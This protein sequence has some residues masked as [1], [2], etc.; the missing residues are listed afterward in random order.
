MLLLLQLFHRRAELSYILPIASF[1]YAS[2]RSTQAHFHLFH[3]NLFVCSSARPFVYAGL[4]TMLSTKLRD[5]LL[6]KVTRS[7]SI[8]DSVTRPS[9]LRALYTVG[10]MCK[11]FA[12]EDLMSEDKRM[13]STIS[14]VGIPAHMYGN[15]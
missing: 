11:H 13:V 10:L 7:S 6:T 15:R 8:I 9:V 2:F 12:L 1:V 14:P 3:H 5:A 4:L